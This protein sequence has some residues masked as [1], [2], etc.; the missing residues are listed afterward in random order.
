MILQ[1]CDEDEEEVLEDMEEGEKDTW[2]LYELNG[3]DNREPY[4]EV[5][6]ESEEEVLCL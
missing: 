4:Q 3:G 1:T 5:K 6:R 2:T